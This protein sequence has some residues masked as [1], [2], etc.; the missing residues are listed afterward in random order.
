MIQKNSNSFL[1]GLYGGEQ[2][3]VINGVRYI[4]ESRFESYKDKNITTINDRFS[5]VITGD[6]AEL[7]IEKTADTIESEYISGCIASADAR[8]ED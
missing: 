7:P 6:F 2:E 5:K 1:C 3:Y 4:V 8:R